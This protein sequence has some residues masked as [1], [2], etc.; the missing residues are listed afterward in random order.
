[1]VCELDFEEGADMSIE[2]VKRYLKTDDVREISKKE[3]NKLGEDIANTSK[4]QKN[5]KSNR[6]KDKYQK[7]IDEM[8]GR[9]ESI[10]NRIIENT[11]SPYIVQIKKTGLKKQ[12]ALR[13]P[14]LDIDKKL[15]SMAKKH[16]APVREI[17]LGKGIGRAS[18]CYRNDRR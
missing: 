14:G 16:L 11:L 5:V 7:S 1:M 4:N 3:F 13:V 2:V 10:L 12:I 15:I 18:L 9:I 17:E 6:W 8:T